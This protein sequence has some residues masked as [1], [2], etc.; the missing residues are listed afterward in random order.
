MPNRLLASAALAGA[1]LTSALAAADLP[2]PPVPPEDA[3]FTA[4]QAKLLQLDQQ[5]EKAKS[6]A[7]ELEAHDE[8]SQEADQAL[9]DF[10]QTY[11]QSAHRWQAVQWFVER[12][13]YFL[14]D[15]KPDPSLSEDSLL[16]AAQ[17]DSQAQAAWRQKAVAWIGRM[18]AAP[19]VDPAVLLGAHQA[20]L[21][22]DLEDAE[23][24]AR[25]RQPVDLAGYRG[26]VYQH[27]ARFAS[28]NQVRVVAYLFIDLVQAVDPAR[29]DEEWKAFIPSPNPRVR[30]VAAARVAWARRK[31]APIGLRFVA[32]D[33]RAVDLEQLR[34][35]VVLLDFWATWCPPC[36]E[37]IP[38]VVAVYQKYHRQGLEIVGIA[39]EHNPDSDPLLAFTKAHGMTWAQLNGG[40]TFQSE[41]ALSFGIYSIPHTVLLDRQ[42]RV[43][44]EDVRGP[45]L[46]PAV[47]QQ[48]GR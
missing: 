29:V 7:A 20:L 12:R 36:R 48:L 22:G 21:E 45:T 4:L 25:R 1:L 31:A 35:R 5:E 28:D 16:A 27:I 15:L 9:I 26:R 3:A 13:P 6:P 18:D 37:E 38:N 46:E 41:A 43:V 17:P 24:A 44:T 39:L 30:E 10:L 33:G 47:R 34:G 14:S 23:R 11:P 19:G 40:R 8:F 32:A 2:P 42:G